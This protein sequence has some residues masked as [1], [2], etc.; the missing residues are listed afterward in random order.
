[1]QFVD[2]RD[3]AAWIL[4]AC[5]EPISGTFSVTSP[6][7]PLRELLET[8]RDA[9]ESD[10][11]FTWVSDD[12]LREHGVDEWMQLPLWLVDPDYKH[13]LEAD[14]SKALAAGLTLRPIAETVRDTLAGAETV[15]GVG[16]EPEKERR[17]L[18][19]ARAA[20]GDA[21]REERGV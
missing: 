2:V 6:V 12:L 1:V 7:L 16:L 9:L 4:R 21:L 20:G 15:D 13:M 10:A 14:V 11:S 18:E 3:L 19:Q 5:T 8:C 17:L